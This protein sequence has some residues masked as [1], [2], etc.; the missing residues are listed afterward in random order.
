[1][2]ALVAFYWFPGF[3]VEG[4]FRFSL[5]QSVLLTFVFQEGWLPFSFVLTNVAL[6]T[7]FLIVKT[8]QVH[9]EIPTIIGPVIAVLL[10]AVENLRPRVL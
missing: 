2:F 3:G 10:A 9:C 5:I 6:K 8:F 1:M 4:I 7:L